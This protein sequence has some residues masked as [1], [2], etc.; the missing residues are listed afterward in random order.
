MQRPWRGATYWLACHRLLS[1]LS[2]RIQDHQTRDTN[3]HNGLDP[4]PL[5]TNF[6][7][8]LQACLQP[9]LYACIIFFDD[10]FLLLL[11]LIILFVYISSDIPPSQLPLHQTFHSIFPLPLPFDSMRIL[12]HPVTYSFLAPLASLYAGASNLPPLPLMSDKP[13]LCYICIWSLAIFLIDVPFFL[14][15]CVKLT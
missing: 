15:T 4:P 8:V 1:L 11:L 9:N 5:I 6:K 7:N 10:Y 3:I 2:F 13:I 12:F 14:M